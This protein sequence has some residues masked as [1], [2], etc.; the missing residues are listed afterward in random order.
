MVRIFLIFI[1]IDLSCRSK[2]EKSI[3]PEPII[4]ES[5]NECK[6]ILKN[7]VDD[8]ILLDSLTNIIM[9]NSKCEGPS[10]GIFQVNFSFKK[11]DKFEIDSVLLFVCNDRLVINDIKLFK[12]TLY[13]DPSLN[14]MSEGLG[15]SK[16]KVNICY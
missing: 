10:Y 4:I 16:V 3:L 1:L 11:I 5:K 12:E 6:C 14:C 7:K 8:F 13:L 15:C 9:R 2:I